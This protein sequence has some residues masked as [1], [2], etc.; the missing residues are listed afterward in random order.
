MKRFAEV[1][2][3]DF[4]AGSFV[5]SVDDQFGTVDGAD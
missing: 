5:E 4:A 1:V 3:P 2:G